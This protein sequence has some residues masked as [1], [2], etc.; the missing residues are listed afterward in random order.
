MH[1][2]RKQEAFLLFTL[3]SA[4]TKEKKLK[5]AVAKINDLGSIVGLLNT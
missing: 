3:N 5:N 1:I 4:K 2:L